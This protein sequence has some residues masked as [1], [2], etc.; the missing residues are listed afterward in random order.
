MR[1][2]LSTPSRF[3]ALVTSS[4]VSNLSK[5]EANPPGSPQTD[6]ES[7]KFILLFI[8]LFYETKSF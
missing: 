1:P 2:Q 8:L 4:S 6:I 5:L 7:L 3:I